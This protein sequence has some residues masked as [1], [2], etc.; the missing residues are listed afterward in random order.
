MRLCCRK[1]KMR[2][3]CEM[4]I[5]TFFVESNTVQFIL[6]IFLERIMVFFAESKYSN[7]VLN[8]IC[9]IIL[10]KANRSLIP[11]RLSFADRQL[12]DM[13][14]LHRK[15]CYHYRTQTELQIES[16]KHKFNWQAST[17]RT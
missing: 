15:H 11:S 16:L 1:L 3:L 7:F 17:R 5:Q 4:Q 12:V 8:R 2:I 13:S 10:S 9:K 6:N 14:F